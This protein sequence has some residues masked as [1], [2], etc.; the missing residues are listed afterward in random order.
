MTNTIF[1]DP[2]RNRKEIYEWINSFSLNE[3]SIEVISKLLKSVERDMTSGEYFSAILDSN[4]V[5]GNF[6]ALFA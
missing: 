3:E 5:K 6:I 4:S 2:F 1:E